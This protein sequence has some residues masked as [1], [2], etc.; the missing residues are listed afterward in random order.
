MAEVSMIA[1][2]VSV[3]QFDR[4]AIGQKAAPSKAARGYASGILKGLEFS[5]TGRIVKVR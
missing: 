1:R 3:I 4:D 5:H 2:T